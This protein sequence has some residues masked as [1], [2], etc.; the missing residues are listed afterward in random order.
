MRIV[1]HAGP[2]QVS[3]RFWCVR[4]VATADLEVDRIGAEHGFV[5]PLGTVDVADCV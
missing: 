3:Q 5:G 1:Q 4:E 2:Q